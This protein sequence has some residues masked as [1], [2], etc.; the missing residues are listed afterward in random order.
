MAI[1]SVIKLI[2]VIL[3]ILVIIT[4]LYFWKKYRDLQNGKL[5]V[6]ELKSLYRKATMGIILMVIT[7]VVGCIV[8]FLD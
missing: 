3:C 1:I 6:A 5:E 2:Y 8:T 4:V 7:F